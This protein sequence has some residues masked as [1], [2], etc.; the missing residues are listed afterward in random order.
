MQTSFLRSKQIAMAVVLAAAGFAGALASAQTVEVPPAPAGGLNFS[1]LPDVVGIHLGMPVQQAVAVVKSKWPTDHVKV[2][3]AKFATSSGSWISRVSA[4]KPGTGNNMGNSVDD[5]TVF[6]SAPP[7]PQV[8]VQ[9]SRTSFMI[10]PTA[11]GN[12]VAALRQKYGHEMKPPLSFDNMAWEFD[13]QG[14]PVPMPMSYIC[15]S[16]NQPPQGQ[17]ASSGQPAELMLTPPYTQ[18]IDTQITRLVNMCKDAITITTMVNPNQDPNQLISTS[19]VVMIDHAEDLRDFIATSR[20]AE[21]AAA[22][23]AD[24][25]RQQQLKNAPAAPPL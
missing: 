18:P 25:Q 20:Y 4:S 2:F 6:F 24:K 1:K 15:T 21:A 11:R 22:A 8:V 3:Y 9:I 19:T 13:E 10:P 16:F 7:N 14:Q 23:A 5:I 17:E 12:L